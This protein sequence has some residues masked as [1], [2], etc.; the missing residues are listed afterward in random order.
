MP[1]SLNSLPVVPEYVDKLP[2][3]ALAGPTT[4]DPD[5][6]PES[7][8]ILPVV[9]EYVAMPPDTAEAGPTTTDDV[10]TPESVMIL[11]LMFFKSRQVANNR[12]CW[13]RYY[14]TGINARIS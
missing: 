13:I 3:T 7:A 6:T 12:G 2:E 14:I 5:R 1:E 10:T 11:P 8:M 4:N 9:P